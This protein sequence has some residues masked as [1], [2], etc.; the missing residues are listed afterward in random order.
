M[1]VDALSKIA[2][3]I[4][5]VNA[6]H[7][8]NQATFWTFFHRFFSD[9]IHLKAE[10]HNPRVSIYITEL[11]LIAQTSLHNVVSLSWAIMA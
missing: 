2:K 3:C 7:Y 11:S 6:D 5:I 4:L 10:K 9:G 1:S 8:I